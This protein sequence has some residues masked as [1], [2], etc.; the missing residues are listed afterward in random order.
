MVITKG[1]IIAP[2]IVAPIIRGIE[3]AKGHAIAHARPR[4]FLAREVYLALINDKEILGGLTRLVEEGILRDAFGATGICYI[5]EDG[6]IQI[7]K[8]RDGAEPP[9]FVHWRHLLAHTWIA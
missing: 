9:N 3:K 6:E 2:A 1:I 7:A 5:A 4:I 8:K